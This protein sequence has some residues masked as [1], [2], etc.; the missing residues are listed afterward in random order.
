MNPSNLIPTKTMEQL[1]EDA[2]SNLE[3]LNFRITNLRKTGGIFNT[4]LAASLQGLAELYTLLIKVVEQIYLFSA[5]GGW[6]DAK[7]AEYSAFRKKATA[8]QGLVVFGRQDTAGILVIPEGTVVKTEPD[9]DGQEYR[10][11]T[12]ARATMADGQAEIQVP[13]TAESEGA[14]YNVTPGLIKRLAVFLSGIDYVRNDAGWVTREGTDEE[15]DEALRQRA[16]RKWYQLSVGGMAETLRSLVEQVNGVVTVRIEDQHPRGEGT[17]DVIITSVQGVP[18]AELVAEVQ[19]LLEEKASLIKDIKAFAAEAV[20]VPVHATLY[21]DPDYGDP[22]KVEPAGQLMI[23]ETFRYMP[24]GQLAD[25]GILRIHP[26]FGVDQSVIYANL[27]GIDNVVKVE[28][29]EPAADVAIT[30]RQVAV[31]G[32]V[33]LEV[34]KAVRA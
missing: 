6:L 9:L 1:M 3:A 2:V 7:A 4:L 21:I 20:T 26:D 28:L 23:S 34:I 5:A 19:T 32:T 10:Y 33:T 30:R 12:T 31:P 25:D 13:V 14:A 24:A 15:S 22:E 11:V 8:T 29:I 27:R 18:T 17:V 16:E